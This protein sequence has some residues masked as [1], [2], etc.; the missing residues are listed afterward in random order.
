MGG[1]AAAGGRCKVWAAAAA[2][3]V[4]HP[5][6]VR[7]VRSPLPPGAHPAA[8]PSVLHSAGLL[9][10][11]EPVE[12]ALLDA[13]TTRGAAPAAPEPVAASSAAQTEASE[14]PEVDLEHSR[15]IVWVYSGC[16]GAMTAGVLCLYGSRG[17]GVVLRIMVYLLALSA[18]TISVKSVYIN[19]DFDFPKFISC[20][21]FACCAVL[22]GSI[23]GWQRWV[24]GRP[25]IVPKASQVT[26]AIMPIALAFAAS[27]GANNL[28][29]SYSGAGFVEM[30]GGCT[31]LCTV[32]LTVMT[33]HSFEQG[34]TWPVVL[35][36]FGIT[37]CATGE[38]AF[39]SAG[40]MLATFAA[41]SR[42]V[43]ST[44]QHAL[45]D[46]DGTPQRVMEPAELL[47]WMSVP[48]TAVM[49]A[50]SLATEGS[51][52]YRR[53]AGSD[54]VQLTLA[55]GLTCANACVLNISNLFVIRDLGAV[56]AQL[57]SQL[58]GVLT[59]LGGV[60]LLGESVG[61]VQICGFGVVLF[62]VFWYNRVEAAARLERKKLGDANKETLPLRGAPSCSASSTEGVRA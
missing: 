50:W 11:L 13:R 3:L 22:C 27:I 17:V 49:L 57:A 37:L 62:G 38:L 60:A 32:L 33:G 15:A 42:A 8:A 40:F 12:A 28:A 9:G 29:L 36:C 7:A 26:F 30:V 20:I 55:V 54:S 16:V 48:S 46:A 52:P 14:V 6:E 59:V 34:L 43:R 56:G 31:P 24:E 39:S 58:K 51:A 25:V 23:L 4:L 61:P 5:A 19:H 41:L 10:W 53:F 44:M 18:M 21:H 45:L 35:V 1:P 47:A 2:L